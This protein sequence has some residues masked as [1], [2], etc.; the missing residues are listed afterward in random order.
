MAR[1]PNSRKEQ[2]AESAVSSGSLF[3][4]CQ[5]AR[6]RKWRR[7]I[8]GP[9]GRLCRRQANRSKSRPRLDVKELYL[10]CKQRSWQAVNDE[11]ALKP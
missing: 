5:S 2:A 9:R 8:A 3:I 1:R 7:T 10:G 6:P 11:I 4:A